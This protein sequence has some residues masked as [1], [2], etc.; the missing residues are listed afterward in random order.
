MRGLFPAAAVVEWPGALIPGLVNAH[1]H[2]QYTGMAALGRV[3]YDSFESWSEAFEEDYL[4]RS[5]WRD[6]ALAGARLLL[7][8]GT[9]AAGDVVTHL[10]AL[11]A[12]HSEGVHGISPSGRSWPGTS[13]TGSTAAAIR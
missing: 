5:Q 7:A 1:T 4:R 2:L 6:P 8:S 9:T 13:P 3:R 10:E 12:L 11:D